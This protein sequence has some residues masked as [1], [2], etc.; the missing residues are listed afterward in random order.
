MKRLKKIFFLSV[1]MIFLGTVNLGYTAPEQK[2]PIKI[3]QITDFTN[4][5]IA[6]YAVKE[7]A[8]AQMAV[9]EINAKGGL[10]GRNLELVIADNSSDMTL[11]I[12]QARRLK[13]QGI[14]ALVAGST[15]TESIAY[16][17]WSKD[18]GQI[19]IFQAYGATDVVNGHPWVFRC[20][21]NDTVTAEVS[22]LVMQK[23]RKTKVGI[24]HTTLAYGIDL[25]GKI[26]KYASKYGVKIV[27]KEALEFR[28]PD[29]TVQAMKLKDAGA[30]GIIACDYSV[31]VATFIRAENMLGWR[32]PL[33]SSWG[34]I[35]NA[36]GL[37][38]PPTLMDGAI[39]QSVC[40][41]SES[42]V[43]NLLQGYA[44]FTK[45]EGDI[46]DAIML[47]YSSVMVLARAIEGAK[48]ADDPTAIRNALY[49]LKFKDLPLG[50]KGSVLTFTP[51]K[52]W[53]IPVEEFSFMVVKGG[54]LE[55]LAFE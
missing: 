4:P 8:A 25:S 51:E 20:S 1:C 40:D 53:L 34:Q 46:D 52:N 9:K 32:P 26:E 35:D 15:S 18:E 37:F 50:R 5:A 16:A 11:A 54:K 7:R 12:S 38:S 17:K 3:G 22:L 19:P 36:L 48:T 42:R 49:K 47:G 6:V 39:A 55:P 24:M 23:L 27:G 30:E 41:H 10:L 21:F 2:P 13:E 33:T 44:K 31:G 29:A 28:S 43:K 14:I 45:R